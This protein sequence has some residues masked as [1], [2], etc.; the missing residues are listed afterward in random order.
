M[1]IGTYLPRLSKLFIIEIHRLLFRREP[2]PRYEAEIRQRTDLVRPHRIPL[3]LLP[4][5]S[6]RFHKFSRYVYTLEGEGIELVRQERG[7]GVDV[8][9]D[10]QEADVKSS[11][12]ATDVHSFIEHYSLVHLCGF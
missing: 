8:S 1:T 7:F 6:H 5:R 4:P 2:I 9:A 3:Y 12:E 10:A 11:T